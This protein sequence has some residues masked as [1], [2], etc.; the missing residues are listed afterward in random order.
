MLM[1][2]ALALVNRVYGVQKL[3]CSFEGIYHFTINDTCLLLG[4]EHN[5][6]NFGF[7]HYYP[8]H[9]IVSGSNSYFEMRDANKAIKEAAEHHFDIKDEFG[10][11]VRFGW[12]YNDDFTE[13]TLWLFQ[14]NKA[15]AKWVR[16]NDVLTQ[17]FNED[18]PYMDY[19]EEYL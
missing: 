14:L 19:I 3:E 8:D 12:L 16:A 10:H 13:R 15:N 7:A 2:D 1:S 17:L 6:L 5:T 18:G 9:H 4:T 11:N